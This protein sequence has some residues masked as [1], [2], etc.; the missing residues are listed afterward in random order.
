MSFSLGREHRGGGQGGLSRHEAAVLR[1]E[2]RLPPQEEGDGSDTAGA[3]GDTA[4]G[5]LSRREG[6]MIGKRS[7]G[8]EDVTALPP[9]SLSKGF[10][11]P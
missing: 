9:G 5:S 11:G 4:P 3:S 1:T 10:R 2:A 8:A 7:Q 6:S